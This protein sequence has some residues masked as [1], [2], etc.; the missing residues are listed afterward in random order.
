MSI[1]DFLRI[2]FLVFGF[3]FGFGLA[4]NMICVRLQLLQSSPDSRASQAASQL[5]S[6]LTRQ[7]ASLARLIMWSRGVARTLD[8]L[9]KIAFSAKQLLS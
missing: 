3:L 8:L 6:Q 9:N 7:P 4:E 2:D 5:A 1:Q